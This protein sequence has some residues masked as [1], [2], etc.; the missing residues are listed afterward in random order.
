MKHLSYA[1]IS[2]CLAILLTV[3]PHLSQ[4]MGVT[5][6]DD[7]GGG[8]E[9]PKPDQCCAA[10]P[11]R[12][13]RDGRDGLPGPPG[14]QGE[15]GPAGSPGKDG[16]RGPKGDSAAVNNDDIYLM[17][18]P[19]DVKF[20]RY[21]DRVRLHETP[22]AGGTSISFNAG[23]TANNR[24][25]SVTLVEPNVL[26]DSAR[27]VVTATISHRNPVSVTTDMD[28]YV[29]V[30]DGVGAVGYLILDKA[31]RNSK[32]T[33]WPCEGARGQT[34][35]RKCTVVKSPSVTNFSPLH[36]VQVKFGGHHGAFGIGKTVSEVHV[37][38]PHAFPYIL[39]PSKG[40]FLDMYRN[41]AGERYIIDFIEVRLEKET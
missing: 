20:K 8:E 36:T 9:K 17:I 38:F 1:T 29:T 30:S 33:M 18:T 31:N 25:M 10:Q 23:S 4:S 15:R 2:G 28:M 24:L 5:P 16:E 39:K 26:N 34:F 12:D 13:G 19:N 27:Y 41:D 37:I 22:A 21:G 40:I 3:A 6:P 14:L 7:G 11:G 32:D 35:N